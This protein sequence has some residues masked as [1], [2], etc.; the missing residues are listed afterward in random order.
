MRRREWRNEE[1]PVVALA[2]RLADKAAEA[3]ASQLAV[4]QAAVPD[5]MVDL[6]DDVAVPT[7]RE[8]RV[9]LPS[10]TIVHT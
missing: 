7:G 3:R 4:D 10:V 8:V 9:L 2:K 1:L 6:D 5:D